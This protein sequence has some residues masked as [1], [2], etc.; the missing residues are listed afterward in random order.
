MNCLFGWSYKSNDP[1]PQIRFY[2]DPTR[3][4]SRDGSHGYLV[5]TCVS[6]IQYSMHSR[7][8]LELEQQG[9]LKDIL[10]TLVLHVD[11]L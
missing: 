11:I 10:P 8:R 1:S 5:A 9:C 6:Y 7:G 2:D 4:D 3:V